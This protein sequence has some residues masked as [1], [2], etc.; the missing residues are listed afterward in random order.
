MIMQYLPRNQ[1]PRPL[2][3]LPIYMDV[4]LT[5][6]GTNTFDVPPGQSTKSYEF[7]L[8]LSGRLIGYGGHM[9]DYGVMVRLEDVTTGKEIARVTSTRDSLGIVSKVSRSLP[10]IK[11]AGVKLKAN[12][13]YRV[14]AYYDNPT[15]EMIKNGAMGHIAGLFAPDD[16]AK[17]PPVDLADPVFQRDLASLEMRGMQMGEGGHDHGGHDHSEMQPNQ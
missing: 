8:P 14:V 10:G 17:W 5:V 11:G 7:S 12:H 3:V 1:N 13:P 15:G 9:H 6:G 4:N 2:P 16:M